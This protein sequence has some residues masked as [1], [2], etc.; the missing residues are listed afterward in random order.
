[1]DDR[2]GNCLVRIINTRRQGQGN[3]ALL[4][5]LVGGG[6]LSAAVG[7][8]AL[9]LILNKGPKAP[10]AY[11]NPWGGGRRNNQVAWTADPAMLNRLGEEVK[12]QGYRIRPP[13]GYTLHEQT[14]D[15]R[16]KLFTWRGQKRPNGSVPRLGLSVISLLPQEENEPLRDSLDKLL[17]GMKGS[18]RKLTNFSSSPP[19]EGQINGI[20]FLRT[21][22]TGS[23]PATGI[24]VQAFAYVGRDGPNMIIFSGQAREPDHEAPIKLTEAAVL[25]F[26]K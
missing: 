13:K 4:W 21:R 24:K 20:P 8:V 12:I 15:K 18:Q 10:Q 26:K 9:L 6:V 25:T 23:N 22:L 17:L 16:L 2:E 11:G 14:I 19:E 7:V 5:S 3:P 1:V